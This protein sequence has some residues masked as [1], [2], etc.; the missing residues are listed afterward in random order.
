MA[1]DGDIIGE[2]LDFQVGVGALIEMATRVGVLARVGVVFS[3]EGSWSRSQSRSE[4]L[5]C[6]VRGFN[7]NGNCLGG[8]G[9]ST[10]R[11]EALTLTRCPQTW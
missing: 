11:N 5:E 6:R 2:G 3:A 4:I 8:N 1:I 9:R 10:H 7:I